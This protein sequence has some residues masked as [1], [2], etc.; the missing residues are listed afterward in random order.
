MAERVKVTFAAVAVSDLVE[1]RAYYT[2]QGVPE[3]GER[4]LGEILNLVESLS[5]HPDKGR[6]VPEFG[7]SNLRELIHPP[8]RIV[9]RR[10]QTR[11]R[12]VR[13]WRSERLLKLPL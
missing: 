8:F 9:Y 2:G 10:D 11:A 5:L 1:I 7:R 13:I 4:L 3:V 12:V 6:I